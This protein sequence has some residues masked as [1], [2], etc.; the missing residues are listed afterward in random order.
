MKYLAGIFVFIA[1]MLFF[2]SPLSVFADTSVSIA[3]TGGGSNSNVSV[4]SQVQGESTVCT[5]GACTTSGGGGTTTICHNGQCTTTD[6]G[7]VDYQSQGGHTQIHVNT[8]ISGNSV[9]ETQ[10]PSVKNSPEPT[11]VKEPTQTPDPT[12]M[13]MRKEINN[14]ISNDV[15]GMKEHIKEQS[16]ALAAFIQSEITSLQHF[17]SGMFR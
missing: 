1:S 12:I 5:N 9:S 13:Q 8:T 7:N 10:K 14:E 16:A 6:N 11:G 4:K 15:E 2:F 17:L 3:N